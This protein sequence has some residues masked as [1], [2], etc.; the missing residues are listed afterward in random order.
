MARSNPPTGDTA[1]TG[2]KALEEVTAAIEAESEAI[3]DAASA[4]ATSVTA[5]AAGAADDFADATETVA[6]AGAHLAVNA[7]SE[8]RASLASNADGMNN[9]FS[10]TRDQLSSFPKKSNFLAELVQLTKESFELQKSAINRLAAC[11]SPNQLLG[12]QF[13]VTREAVSGVADASKRLSQ[14]SLKDLA[15]LTSP[16]VAVA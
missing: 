11:R 7:T 16:T 9:A 12:V 6:E 14:A 13:E 2:F 8:A 10:Q 1:A 5:T 4:S 15:Q 3:A